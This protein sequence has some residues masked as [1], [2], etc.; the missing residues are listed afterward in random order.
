MLRGRDAERTAVGALVDEAWASRGGA[1]VIRGLAGV[2]K[3]ALLADA[4]ARAEGM[5]V[6]TTRG[7]ESESPLPFAAL[8]RLLRP[9]MRH[10]DRLPQPQGN[11]LRAALGEIEGDGGDRFRVFLATLNVLAAA[12]D[13]GPILAVV[14]DA[15]WLDD[16]SAA[17]LLFAARRVQ[18]ERVTVLF[19]AREGDVRTFDSGDLPS[20]SLS[21]ID[22][23]AARALLS[24]RAGIPVPAQ[25]SDRLVD[26]TGGMPLALVELADALPA[27]Q[28]RGRV[29]LP[30]QLPLTEGVERVF[31]DRYRRL[32][33][34]AR[35]LLLVMSADDSG[36]LGLVHDA[37]AALGAS[38]EALDA[39]E[40]S[41][42]VRVRD[43][44]VELRHPL[45]RSAVYGGAT[46]VERRRVH[47]ALADALADGEEA[48]RRVWH[49]AAATVVPDG[50]VVAELD[51]AAERARSRGGLEAAA[52]AWE[53]AAELT[54]D[55]EHRAQRLYA[56]ARMAW[57]AAQA[58]RA[59]LLAERALQVTSDPGL[60][61][62][63]ARLRA[64]IEWNIGS[65]HAGHRMV[66]HAAKDVVAFDPDRAREM[67]MFGAAL[68]TFGAD[69]GIEIDPVQFAATDAADTVRTRCFADLLIGLRHVTAGNWD[70]AVPPLRHAFD[71]TRSLAPA[72][73]DLLPNLGIAALHLGDD[74]ASRRYHEM[75]RH[76]ARETGAIFMARYALTRLG[77]MELAVGRWST[78]SAD[79]SRALDLAEGMGQ[80]GLTQL[81]LACL[82]LL[83]AFRGD[84]A[85]DARLARLERVNSAHP[86]GIMVAIVVDLIK[87]AKGITAGHP[88]SA[89][90]HLE[91]ISQGMI[92][93][94]AA[95]DRV[96]AA[97]RADHHDVASIWVAEL[98]EF[99]SATGEAWASAATAHGQAMLADDVEAT[100]HFEQ[101]LRCHV[102]STRIFDR[103]RTQL[104]YGEFL[105]RSRR[106]VDART[107][108]RAA[109]E[110]FDDLG[111][112]PW[113]DRAAQELRASG[114]T[115]RRRDP[116]TVNDLTPQELQVAR[117]VGQGMSNREAASQL[118]LSPRTIDFH[119]RNVY[120]KLGVSSRVELAQL[121]L[122]DR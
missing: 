83:A 13:H 87:W 15:H 48:D 72:D 96:E 2:G 63:A 41:G 5:Q 71:L 55:D 117:L 20:L 47:Q 34:Q 52:A 30:A 70:Q 16:A 53:R 104:A 64:R 73:H 101:A 19:A 39:V 36:R 74:A 11:A 31:L 56:A 6:L 95:I 57:L 7:I 9:V 33:E 25:V 109:L 26:S 12:A 23:D 122:D 97:V 69:S 49:R 90:G 59:R 105:R 62:D 98:D 110:T 115:A 68:E 38:E 45:V 3:S 89:F 60:R 116:A 100:A 77:F 119:L 42:L 14:D 118:Y 93:R 94:M 80:P 103:A 51:A 76:W 54:R 61:A 121:P 88:A 112:Q 27:D 40:R 66:M 24:D 85:Y 82:T 92:R 114:E 84:D 21:G 86:T 22:P 35:T 8:H 91:Q 99:A 102:E 75:L 81:P 107:Q 111:A 65:L 32:P 120:A 46:S 78:A 43:G 44:D 113:V 1:L 37:A 67:A 17:A 28:L 18:N 29:P 10:V 50:S 4:M 58:D 108:L 106:R 79:A